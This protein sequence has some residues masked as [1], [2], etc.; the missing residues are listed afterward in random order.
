MAANEAPAAVGRCF[1]CLTDQ[2]ESAGE[3]WVHPCP[4]SLEGH[5]DCMMHWLAEL[6]R[7]NKPFQCPVCKAAIS[8]DEPFDP[9]V[10]VGNRLH[11]AFSRLSPPLLGTGLAIG[12]W[13]GLATY[14]DVAFQIFAGPEARFHFLNDPR[15]EHG[16]RLGRYLGLGAV[17]PTLILSHSIPGLGNVI[18]LPL[19][20]LFGTFH[21]ARDEHFF[22]WPP[23]PEL[24]CTAF[25]YVRAMYR[26]LWRELIRP[27]ENKLDRRIAGLPEPE[28]RQDQGQRD[29]GHHHHDDHDHGHD[30]EGGIAGMLDA[31]INLL[32]IPEVDVELQ[33]EEQIV[34]VGEDDPRL[35]QEGFRVEIHEDVEFDAPADGE[36]IPDLIAIEEQRHDEHEAAPAPRVAGAAAAPP[37]MNDQRQWNLHASLR[38]VANALA[39]ALL[40]PAISSGAGELIQLLLPKHLTTLSGKSFGRP[41]LL[42][43]T[44]GRSLV[45]GC[46][47]LVLRDAFKL[48]TKYRRA[49]NRPLRK[50]RN[51]DRKRPGSL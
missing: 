30:D 18:F 40:L 4:C 33:V 42:Q 26:N 9:A 2:D 16:A 14:G 29:G 39:S 20:A 43:Q 31:A 28:P 25:P 12:T 38:D 47:Y 23:S 48:Y 27:Y 21:M 34:H 35:G 46:M 36:Q 5:Q 8:V 17:A 1:V 19:A 51:V 32:D 45:G 3:E 49:V 11:Q 15:Q 41:G 22:S 10:A 7:E 24:V 6:E 13:L 37:P 50:V 44:W